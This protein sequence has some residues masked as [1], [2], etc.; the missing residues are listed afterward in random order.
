[1]AAYDV[2]VCFN[3]DNAAFKDGDA[4]SEIARILEGIAAKVRHNGYAGQDEAYRVFDI[5]GNV[6]GEAIIRFESEDDI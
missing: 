1:M 2:Q 6:I 3:T 5:N 4:P